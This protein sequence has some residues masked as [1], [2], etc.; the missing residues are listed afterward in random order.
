M[1]SA[2]PKGYY[3][4]QKTTQPQP[5]HPAA[6]WQGIEQLYDGTVQQLLPSCHDTPQFI[7]STPRFSIKGTTISLYIRVVKWLIKLP[8]THNITRC[9]WIFI[10][11]ELKER[12]PPFP[13]F[14]FAMCTVYDIKQNNLSCQKLSFIPVCFPCAHTFHDDVPW[15]PVSLRINCMHLKCITSVHLSKCKV[16]N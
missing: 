5:S 9:K 11:S 16:I 10:H 12:F 3:K 15:K 7:L 1:G 14:T 2:K 4:K 13:P 8:C 6:V